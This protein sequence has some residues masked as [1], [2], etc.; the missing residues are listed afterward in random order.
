MKR[1]N[2][3]CR[4]FF[5]GLA[6]ICLIEFC[7]CRTRAFSVKLANNVQLDGVSRSDVDFVLAT[8]ESQKQC[9]VESPV[10]SIARG[11]RTNG[12]V[13][14]AYTDTRT[15]LINIALVLLTVTYNVGGWI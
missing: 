13:M 7:G 1:V 14:I 11:A 4:L 10:K 15:H 5:L 3:G 6:V 12:Q 8:L 2:S 9:L